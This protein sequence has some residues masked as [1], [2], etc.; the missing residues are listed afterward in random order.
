MA[1]IADKIDDLICSFE[2]GGDT[3]M[4]TVAM[5]V[6]GW[7]IFGLVVLGVS[8]YV[9]ARFVMKNEDG[10]SSSST[11]VAVPAIAT[12]T[13]AKEDPIA[14]KDV[15]VPAAP[16]VRAAAP[17]LGAAGGGSF[18]PTPTPPIRK[19]VSMS[20]NF[21]GS[22]GNLAGTPSRHPVQPP[23][24]TGADSESVQW[25]NE[26]FYWLYTDSVTVNEILQ[27]WLESLNEFTNKSVPEVS[28]Y[29]SNKSAKH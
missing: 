21:K 19:R 14:A 9:Y 27:L 6:F 5:L 16:V 25:V 1:D 8:K 3:T 11:T 20:K 13:I 22:A 12:A 23:I 29:P 10:V 17:R 7:M 28:F 2:G 15:T 24:S 18:A 26:V 4:D